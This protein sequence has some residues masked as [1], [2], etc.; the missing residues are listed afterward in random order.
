MCAIAPISPHKVTPLHE[1]YMRYLSKISSTA[2]ENLY[3]TLHKKKSCSR[4][5]DHDLFDGKE[6]TIDRFYSEYQI[7]F[8]KPWE[9]YKDF[10]RKDDL[11]LRDGIHPREKTSPK[12]P[13]RMMLFDSPVK[14]AWEETNLA[15]FK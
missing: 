7:Y 4:I 13:V 12:V 6:Y 14:T 1:E 3:Y 15:P 9:F 2:F 11:N 5:L 10:G 8:D